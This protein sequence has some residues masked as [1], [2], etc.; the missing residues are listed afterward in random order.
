MVIEELVTHSEEETLQWAQSFAAKLVRG[1][2]LALQGDLGA[3]KTVVSRG[4]ALGLGFRGGV[5]S[6]SYAL[7]HEYPNDPP[8]YHLDL[9][10]LGPHADLHE[11][12]IE[13]YSFS[14]GITLIEWPERLAG[15]DAG[16]HYQ[17]HIEHINED[18]RRIMVKSLCL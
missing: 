17:I 3:G 16:I 9:Y 7:V 6:P 8:I 18:S 1:D 5:H 11:I 4:I 2:V 14:D 10:R 12:G 15:L 13:H